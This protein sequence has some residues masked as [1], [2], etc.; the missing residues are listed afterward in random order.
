RYI[1]AVNDGHVTPEFP[2]ISDTGG[3][4]PE[5]CVFTLI[6]CVSGIIT[7]LIMYIRYVHIKQYYQMSINKILFLNPLTFFIG[8]LSVFGLLLVGAFQDDEISIVHMIGAAMVFGFGI[9]YM[10]LQTVI[11]YKI[12]HA[13]L[14]RH[15]SS[16]VIILRLFLS[17]MATIFFIMVMV[18]MYV[19]GHI[20]N[21]SSLDY[22]PA[23]WTSKDPG[24]PLHLTSTISEWCLGLAFLVFFLTF[25]TDFS[26]VS[27]IVSVSLR[28]EYMT[29]NENTPLRL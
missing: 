5:S 20:R 3:K 23:H 27:L 28:Q 2:Y 22:D 21:Q 14:T 1:L 4:P 10:W 16:V 29:L 9:V 24:Y 26:R 11:S 17:L 12:Y 13:S 6:C 15:V 19:A 18:T 7:L 8:I 25:H